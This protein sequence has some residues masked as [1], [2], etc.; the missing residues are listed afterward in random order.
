MASH[1]ALLGALVALYFY[2]GAQAQPSAERKKRQPG[3]LLSPS[4][5]ADDHEAALRGA[6]L[7]TSGAGAAEVPVPTP[8]PEI[9][10]QE[11]DTIGE[12]LENDLGGLGPKQEVEP[13]LK[14]ANIADLDGVPID[15]VVHNVSAYIP[16]STEGNGNLGDFGIINVASGTYVDLEFTFKNRQTGQAQQL[17]DFA[18]SVL[19]LDLNSFSGAEIETVIGS[20]FDYVL[21][22]PDTTVEISELTDGRYVF[23]ATWKGSAND[24]PTSLEKLTPGQL[25]TSVGFIYYHVSSFTL[26]FMVGDGNK[27]RNFMFGGRTLLIETESP[28]LPS[29]VV[30]SQP[31]PEVLRLLKTSTPARLSPGAQ[32]A[33]AT[34]RSAV[35]STGGSAESAEAAKVAAEYVIAGGGSSELAAQAGAAAAASVAVGMPSQAVQIAGEVAASTML[36]QGS[37][38]QASKA[39]IAAAETMRS[40]GQAAADA[41]TAA[42]HG[43]VAVSAAAWNAMDALSQGYSPEAVAAAGAAA[44]VAE[45][46]GLGTQSVMAAAQQA[47][48]ATSRGA[49]VPAAAAAG[50]AASM[51]VEEGVD[52]IVA[53]NAGLAAQQTI[54]KRGTAEQAAAAG[55]AVVASSRLLSQEAANAALTPQASTTL[56]ST[57]WVSSEDVDYEVDSAGQGLPGRWGYRASQVGQCSLENHRCFC[58]GEV[59]FG[60]PGLWSTIRQVETDVMCSEAVFGDPSP[61]AKKV[62]MCLPREKTKNRFWWTVYGV[63]TVFLVIQIGLA[64]MRTLSPDRPGRWQ[65]TFEAT[66]PAVPFAPMLCAVILVVAERGEQLGGYPAIMSGLQSAS[67]LVSHWTSTSL[68]QGT[69]NFFGATKMSIAINFLTTFFI[70]E[71]C[72]RVFAK[73]HVWPYADRQHMPKG[74]KR[75]RAQF[76]FSV[77]TFCYYA[78]MLSLAFVIIGVYVVMHGKESATRSIPASTP[79]NEATKNCTAVIILTYFLVHL[80]SHSLTFLFSDHPVGIA[81]MRRLAM[82][83]EIMPMVCSI[84]LAAQLVADAVPMELPMHTGNAMYLCTASML[85]QVI[86]AMIQPFIFGYRLQVLGHW[87]L[88]KAGEA[89]IIVEQKPGLLFFNCFRWMALFGGYFSALHVCWSLYNLGQRVRTPHAMTHLMILGVLVTVYFV[90]EVLRLLIAVR[91]HFE[92]GTSWSVALPDLGIWFQT[93][94][95]ICPMLSMMVVANWLEVTFST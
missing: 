43:E 50:A 71:V 91:R 85:G 55:A 81:L 5:N 20:G 57:S 51:A 1:R 15:L 38:E 62:C 36:M 24:N 29:A 49:S 44:A 75:R 14:W 10:V 52:L 68:P 37:Q 72:C 79:S 90:T 94:M 45:D 33:A 28:Q 84:Y 4:L 25:R 30:N 56:K 35:T 31:S 89:D 88:E 9:D 41:A 67:R 34:A 59:V 74:E 54:E 83:M 23:T 78:M 73:W 42:G 27:G 60:S 80:I 53:A 65:K 6:L 93:F 19:D 58:N 95:D 7:D 48:E 86:L 32:E 3:H 92:Q 8:P 22:D 47:A 61:N 18:F 63:A 13:V 11:Q 64:T 46:A 39:A 66:L 87:D 69:T 26:T 70:C 12:T 40:A 76:W 82:N 21:V 16:T 17:D 77:W 2:I